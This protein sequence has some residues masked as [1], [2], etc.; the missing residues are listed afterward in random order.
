MKP[1]QWTFGPLLDACRRRGDRY[2]AR[3]YGRQMLQSDEP[4]SSFCTNAL[5]RT[6]SVAQ[7]RTLCEECGVAFDT[8][9][10][11]SQSARRPAAKGRGGGRGGDLR[12]VGNREEGRGGGWRRR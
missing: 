12:R 4:L 6:L 9:V 11:S 5:R 8:I 7:L 2:R 1:D 3:R 10:A